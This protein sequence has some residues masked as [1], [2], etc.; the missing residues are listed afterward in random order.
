MKPMKQSPQIFPL[1]T[2]ILLLFLW[3][4]GAAAFAPTADV[5]F[6]GRVRLKQ[7]QSHALTT[8]TYSSTITKTKKF[9]GNIQH[10]LV[11][12][13][14][15]RFEWMIASRNN[16]DDDDDDGITET[17]QK[18]RMKK[19]IIGNLLKAFRIVGPVWLVPSKAYA[20][21]VEFSS[22]FTLFKNFGT[23]GLLIVCAVLVNEKLDNLKTQIEKVE[24]NL[25]NTK[26]DLETQMNDTKNDLKTQIE[27]VET[28]LDNT[29]N[30]LKM[31]IEKVETNLD[32][33][34]DDTKNDLDK[35]IDDTKN[36]LKTQ[37]EKVE[38]NLDKKI[39]D[40]KNDLKTQMNDTMNVQKMQMIDFKND[41]KNDLK[42]DF[43]KWFSL[44][45]QDRL[46]IFTDL[47]ECRKRINDLNVTTALMARNITIL[48]H[49]VASLETRV[50]KKLQ[51][52][53]ND[54]TR[55]KKDDDV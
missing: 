14:T 49:D 47:K 34:I 28:N 26:N 46:E 6:F 55:E 3:A 18:Q 52:Y 10:H 20:L 7:R 32:K 48:Q 37:I 16:N 13:C 53:L 27:K 38:T 5:S 12:V 36:D 31:Q 2:L 9:V 50:E 15:S 23:P 19:N 54:Q 33:K 11:V 45:Q 43:D 40:T 17:D 1:E 24:T 51:D 21:D 41:R 4:L 25:D 30:D 39:D 22:L 44:N 42:N 35:K 29:K 8:T